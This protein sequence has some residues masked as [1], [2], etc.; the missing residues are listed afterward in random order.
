MSI[1]AANHMEERQRLENVV[2]T[3]ETTCS[4][5]RVILTQCERNSVAENM[6]HEEKVE[7]LEAELVKCRVDYQK[8]EERLRSMVETPQGFRERVHK[9]MKSLDELA[10]GLGYAK[11]RRTLLRAQLQ[12]AVVKSV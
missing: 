7:A 10:S 9:R 12:P 2:E 4:E 1:A 5:L 8:L 6:Q 3:L 11:R